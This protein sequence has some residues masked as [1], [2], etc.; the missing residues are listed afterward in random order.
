MSIEVILKLK[1]TEDPV[2]RYKKELQ[3]VINS[4]LLSKLLSK[5]KLKKEVAEFG[6]ALVTLTRH[7][8]NNWYVFLGSDKCTPF[9]KWIT[10]G[11]WEDKNYYSLL[12]YFFGEK[13][14]DYV[15]EAWSRLPQKMFQNGYERRSFRA[16]ANKKYLLVNQINFLRSLVNVSSTYSYPNTTFY[17]LT[18]EE[19]ICFDTEVTNNT[20]QFMLW[21]AAIDMDKT[22]LFELFEDIIFNKHPQGKVS[23]NI[24]KA[25]LNSNKKECWQLVEKL[26]LAAQRQEGLRQT[27]L[28]ALDETSIGAIQYMINVIIEHKLTRFSSVVRAIDTWTGLGWEAEKETTIRNII[29]L[30]ASY[31]SNQ[32][33]IS[34]GIYSKNNN[35]A[36]MALWVQG[37]FDV[38]ATVPYLHELLE[39]GS[40]E[41]KCLAL[42]F[43][44]ETQDPYIEMPLYFK[45]LK[46]D[47]LQVLAFT[48][49]RMNN[50][51]GANS[52]SGF[53]INNA[54]YPGFFEKVYG[55]AQSVTVKN[56]VFESKVFSWLKVTFEKDALYTAAINLIGDDAD[57]L[58][59]ILSHFE[60]MSIDL[61]TTLARRVLG[62]FYQYSFYSSS[63]SPEDDKK[64]PTDFQRNFAL[65]ILK[66]R[67]ESL[68]ASAIYTL[69]KV[70]LRDEELALFQDLFKRKSSNLKKN[71][72]EIILRQKDSKIENFV[73]KILDN[74]DLEQ[75]MSALD[76]MLQLQKKDRLAKKVNNWVSDYALRPKITEKELK[77]IEQLE[78]SKKEE[79]LSAENGYGF[80]NPGQISDYS[81]PKQDNN[82]LYAK[83]VKMHK[84]GFSKPMTHI[85]DEITKLY[86]L[87][88]EHK[89]YEYT[90]E[91]H[92]NRK[93][94]ILLANS[95]RQIKILADNADKEAIIKNYP[96]YGIWCSWFEN[97][98]LAERDLFLLTLVGN[99]DRK[100][101]KDFL[102]KHVFYFFDFIPNPMK[103]AYEWNN[104]ILGIIKALQLNY[105]FKEK[106]DFLIDA[107]SAL[108][109]DMPKDILNYEHVP[110]KNQYYYGPD[111]GK[112]WQSQGFCDI[113]LNSINLE[114]LTKEQSKNVWNLYRWRQLSGLKKN[115]EHAKPPVYMYCLAYEQKIISEGELYEGLVESERLSVLTGETKHYNHFGSEN[116]I[117]KFPFLTPM[118]DQIRNAFLDVEIKRGDSNTPVTHFVQAFQK[119]Y[120]ITRF[121]ELLTGL[122][123]S[124][125]YKGYIYSW[126]YTELTKQKLFSFLLKK[127]YPLNSDTQE[128]FNEHIAT[129]KIS[130]ERLIQAAIYAP[131]WQKYISNYLDWKGLDEGIWWLHAH[132]KTAAYSN[133]NSELESE[134]AKFSV[135]D[136]QDF[137]DGAVDSNWFMSAYKQ[138]GKLK[139]ELL[140]EAAKYVTDGNGH[141]RARLYAD[142]ITGDLK[143]REVT[144]KI[145]N[146]RDQDYLRVYGLVPLSKTSPE[147]DILAR[148]E[149]LQQFKKESREF[150]AMKLT[151]EA[152]A[153]RV[154][155]ENLARNA[156]YPDPV[157]LTWAMETKQVQ[158]ILSKETEVTIDDVAVRLI[159]NEEGKADIVTLKGGKELKA[160][161][162]NIKKDKAILELAGYRKTM[163]EQWIRSKKGLEES[164]VRGD[165]FLFSEI[166]NLFEHPIIS[167]HLEKLVFISNDDRNG[168]Y[169][170]GNLVNA[171]GEIT[172]LDEHQTLRIAHCYDLHKNNVWT[173]YQAYCF[174]NKHIQPFKQVFRELYI[175]TVDELSEKSVSRRYAGHQVHPKQT[176]A[177][178]KNRGWKVDYEEGLQKVFHKE[179]Y[180]VKM[181]AMANWFSPADI[182][183]PTLETIEFHS[184]KDYKNIA[185]E[186]IN[187]R[188]FSEVMRDIDLVVSV[189]HVGGVDPEASHSS[190]EMRVVLI[191]ETLRLFKIK[192]VEIKQ[193]HALVKGTMANYSIHLGS[194]V[195]HQ[196]PGKYLSVLPVHSQHR[197]RLFLPFADDDPKSAEVM[198]KVILF[199]KDDKIQDPTILS[200]ID[201]RYVSETLE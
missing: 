39:K 100:I 73:D 133:V 184:L 33:S 111:K 45:A 101:F 41:K 44:G 5:N 93:E 46:D 9:E 15:K 155:L 25:L 37:V 24:I 131:Q 21:S 82:S 160:V 103:P 152:L 32:E 26:L 97:S 130:E 120:G 127:C 52:K 150:G 116:L 105:P 107:S 125:L 30:A 146:K 172:A 158:N 122:G 68:V 22:G 106:E 16:P 157:R 36:Y 139:W 79:A 85:K 167:R 189:A 115:V 53:Y 63:S 31:F 185:F 75:R 47:N 61:R 91:Y 143:I 190:I 86:K 171:L 137:K 83:A 166:K 196:V 181:Y 14:A 19:Q 43:T 148:Y 62:D 6:L 90:T 165:E 29:Q 153:V 151:S 28:E 177:L 35:E 145:K 84:Y 144:A 78:P 138:L 129:A 200:Q 197:G 126:S 154:A 193:N 173:D 134:A 123:K 149:Y 201:K 195:V 65:R 118:I 128:V 17:D 168:F 72:I 34:T 27:I 108:F 1:V 67:G 117:K 2:K 23:R 20:N 109:S 180:Q 60:E 142:T 8:Y 178:L 140:Y 198:S 112:G 59:R 199:A 58:E 175:P 57:K 11:M 191:K 10:D 174:D 110:P 71:L 74:G 3:E 7:D 182:E 96:L 54:D 64:I 161:P 38:E 12:V 176:L 49:P 40:V 87:F 132:T 169:I 135:I 48:L 18:F 66:D 163:R 55:L 4:N 102:E 124:S 179:G 89:N 104:P 42:K 192:N 99:C 76:M 51:L 159:I 98:G 56:K 95:F 164:M 94:T 147:K 121:I 92:D 194:A 170:N 80:Y 162:P 141:R 113:Y 119:I 183:S 81:L 187:P 13:C 50:L 156:G 88:E 69:K 186:D 70:E 136:L 114:L 77:F 188:I